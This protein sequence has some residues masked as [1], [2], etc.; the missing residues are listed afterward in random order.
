MQL[1]YVAAVWVLFA[2]LALFTDQVHNLSFQLGYVLVMVIVNII[3]RTYLM[4]R[5]P[6]WF[7]A[8]K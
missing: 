7:S 8:K 6:E 2:I 1:S 5:K 3:W 4:K